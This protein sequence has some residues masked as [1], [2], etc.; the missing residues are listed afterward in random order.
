MKKL[1]R[2]VTSKYNREV[3]R[4]SVEFDE[5]PDFKEGENIFN[6]DEVN[7]EDLTFW[8]DP[9]DGSKGFS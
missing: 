6:S 9:L 3:S 5:S 1:R 8:V 2:N 7:E 4:L